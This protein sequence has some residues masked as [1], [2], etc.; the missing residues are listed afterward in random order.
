MPLLLAWPISVPVGEGRRRLI[1][2][3]SKPEN[4]RRLPSFLQQ[5][6]SSWPPS[7]WIFGIIALPFVRAL[8]NRC[9]G[10]AYFRLMGTPLPAPRRMPRGGLRFNEG[11]FVIRIRA[12][13]MDENGNEVPEAGAQQQQQGQEQMD[14]VNPPPAENAAEGENPNPNAAAVEAAEQLIEINASSLGRKVGGALIMPVISSM[15]GNLLFRLSKH[16]SILRSF[17]GIRA[18]VSGSY[19]LP[20]WDLL[21]LVKS[22]SKPLQNG[23][24]AVRQVMS[25]FFGGSPMWLDSD[26]VWYVLYIWDFLQRAQLTVH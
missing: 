14:D 20:S 25:V 23:S 5:T 22:Q 12:N 2:F 21:A 18:R 17:L 10:K 24:E 16:S 9:Y 19:P 26:P 3:W 15:M 13:V 7:P 6:R 4:A 1:D 8:Y 11:P